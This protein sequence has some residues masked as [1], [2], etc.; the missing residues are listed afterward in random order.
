MHAKGLHPAGKGVELEEL[1]DGFYVKSRI[2]EPVA[3]KLALEGIY[4]NYSVG[5]GGGVQI[6]RDG[7]APNGR[8]VGGTMVELSLVDRPANPT[9]K[10]AVLKMATDGVLEEQGGTETL[11][12]QMTALADPAETKAGDASDD[13]DTCDGT[14]KIMEGHRK[15]PDCKGTGNKNAT[16]EMVK[17][18][19][20]LEVIDDA[21]ASAD[22]VAAAEKHVAADVA[23]GDPDLSADAR[24][25][26]AKAGKALPDGSYPTRTKAEFEK[27]VKAYGR[28]KDKPA[29]KAYLIKRAKAEGWTDLL[30]A[31]WEGS[32]KSEGGKKAAKSVDSMPLLAKQIHDATCPGHTHAAAEAMHP[33][34]VKNGVAMTAGPQ[35]RQLF[36]SMLQ[37]EV[38]EDGGTGAGCWDISSVA[39]AYCDVCCFIS[40][41]LQNEAWQIAMQE[42]DNA[43]LAAAH[44]EIRKLAGTADETDDDAIEKGTTRS[45]YTNA[46]KDQMVAAL[47]GVHDSI[48]SI[49]PDVCDAGKV[50]DAQPT[51]DAGPTTPL[52]EM[53]TVPAGAVISQVIDAHE[54]VRASAIPELVKAALAENE[55]ETHKRFEEELAERDRRIEELTGTVE[56]LAAAPDPYMAPVRGRVTQLAGSEGNGAGERPAAE[57]DLDYL[58]HIA[59]KST[60]P[61]LR[62]AAQA[63]LTKRR[64]TAAA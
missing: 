33:S 18:V 15:C 59:S 12:T 9:C 48:S 35:A 49:W 23:K 29:T 41:Y 45:F 56:K 62:L 51:P 24:K 61:S 31:D 19:E 10:A 21:A 26:A 20:S 52:A 36:W 34:L 3:M 63:E 55:S 37:S 27:A 57:T 32:T 2:V 47:R 39:R 44:A 11:R 43:V 1:P 30:P 50:G 4:S 8:I 13:C 42:G 16:P 25:E 53:R 14:G 7:S 40:G 17:S 5:L 58:E 46:A 60:D 38:E 54:Y 64:E 28:A 22:E 6:I